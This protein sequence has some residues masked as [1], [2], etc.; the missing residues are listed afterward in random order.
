V[1]SVDCSISFKVDDAGLETPAVKI[2]DDLGRWSLPE[3]EGTLTSKAENNPIPLNELRDLL[4]NT[5]KT[6]DPNT[7]LSLELKPKQVK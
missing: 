4:K 1:V 3:F 7:K 6:E 2:L 5:L